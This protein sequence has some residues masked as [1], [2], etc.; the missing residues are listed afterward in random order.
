DTDSGP[1]AVMNFRARLNGA[2]AVVICSPEYAHGVPGALKNALDWVVGSGE[3]VGKP[4]GVWNLSARAVHAHASLVETLQTMSA[5][6]LP[7]ACFR[8]TKPSTPDMETDPELLVLIEGA[9][10][11]LTEVARSRVAAGSCEHVIGQ[12]LEERPPGVL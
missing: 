3:L 7:E 10:A 6:V 1:A 4:V 2:A 11:A 12:P 9:V 5:L 8:W